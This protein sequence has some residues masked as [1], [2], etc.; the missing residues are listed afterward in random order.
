ASWTKQSQ[1]DGYSTRL[2]SVILTGNHADSVKSNVF[3][4]C[5]GL[6]LFAAF[7]NSVTWH[8]QT[9]WGASGHFW[10]AHWE[11]FHP[12]FGGNEWIFFLLG[13]AL[14]P[15]LVFW[16]FN[17]I[18]LVADV[19]GKPV[20]FTRYRIQLGKDYPVDTV[21]LCKAIRT[22]LFNQVFIS[23]PMVLLM[24]PIMRWRGELC[25]IELPTFHW[26]LLELAIFS[27]VEEILFYYSHRLLH[28]PLL[29]KH[30]HKKHHEWTAPI[31]V[32]ALYAHPIEHVLSNMVPVLMGPLLLGS[33]VSSIMTW[34][35]LALL[36]TS[37]SHCGYHIPFLPSPE[38]HDYHHLQFNQC[39]GV[40]GV[41][42]RLHGTDTVFRKSKAYLRHTVL[43]SF[44]PFTEIIPDSPKKA[45]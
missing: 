38:F 40:L 9:F 11:K 17:G 29:Y 13:A 30:I 10:Q 15:T 20:F 36:V 22:V 21:K 39:Y 4:L 14:V 25:G 8:M 7:R 24:F 6:L 16:C 37:L 28:H 35:S 45:E 26:F 12:S 34:F 27:L 33:H 3:M 42:D 31:G 23:L 18:L 43:L 41:L 32:V 19:T 2:S 5:T 1:S 44:T